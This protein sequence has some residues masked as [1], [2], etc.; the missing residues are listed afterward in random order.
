MGQNHMRRALLAD[1]AGQAAGI[2]AADADAA[3]A[4]HPDGQF[5]GR[6]PVRGQRRV[7]PHHHPGGDGVLRLVILGGDAGIADMGEGEGDDLAG[8]GGIGHDL[9]I[10]GHRGVED[11]FG[12]HL[13]GG[14][15]APAVKDCAVCK[16]QAS[17]RFRGHG[18]PLV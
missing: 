3:A 17:G 10:A 16:H 8:I 6:A 2:D 9:L 18:A 1:R 4:C 11:Q 12:H 15:E 7:P 5:L 14:A 13:S